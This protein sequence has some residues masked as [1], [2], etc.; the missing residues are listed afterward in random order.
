VNYAGRGRTATQSDATFRSFYASL[1]YALTGG[2]TPDA[3]GP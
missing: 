3:I 2:T 1:W